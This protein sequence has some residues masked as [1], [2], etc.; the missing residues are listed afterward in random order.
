MARGS[1][2]A[3]VRRSEVLTSLVVTSSSPGS[4]HSTLP[5][6]SLKSQERALG[7]IL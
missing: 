4:Q 5:A 2:T 6:L 3:S 7:L 1:H